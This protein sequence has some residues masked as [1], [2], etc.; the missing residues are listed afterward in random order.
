MVD[1]NQDLELIKLLNPEL[2]KTKREQEEK[3]NGQGDQ[4]YDEYNYENNGFEE[5]QE[6]KE[7]GQGDQDYD[8]LRAELSKVKSQLE[9]AKK[10]LKQEE[11]IS[12]NLRTNLNKVTSELEE[13]KDNRN[14]LKNELEEI[15]KGIDEEATKKAELEETN[16]IQ[17]AAEEDRRKAAVALAA[18]KKREAAQLKRELGPIS[19][20]LVAGKSDLNYCDQLLLRL[21][22]EGGIKDA[23]YL[24]L[25]DSFL[26]IHGHQINQTNLCTDASSN[27]KDFKFNLINP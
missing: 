22:T 23:D 18:Q 25:R 9:V 24:S 20:V 26:N 10:Y 16:R 17:R 19:N 11:N 1:L 8:N 2:I 3:E 27:F 5:E 21:K 7:N 13:S 14:V 6:G 15:A 4:Q 12:T